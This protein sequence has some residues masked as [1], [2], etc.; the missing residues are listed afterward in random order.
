M[1]QQPSINAPARE[2]QFPNRVQFRWLYIVGTALMILAL[3]G[4]MVASLRPHAPT[5][6]FH[7]TAEHERAFGTD[8]YADRP[9]T[10]SPQ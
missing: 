2:P 4:R 7:G 5:Q 3:T 10:A 6:F 8:P 9:S 1:E